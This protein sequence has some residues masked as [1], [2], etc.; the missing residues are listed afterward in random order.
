MCACGETV[1]WNEQCLILLQSKYDWSNTLDPRLRNSCHVMDKY[2][3]SHDYF[4]YSVKHNIWLFRDTDPE[5]SSFIIK[6]AGKLAWK[7]VHSCTSCLQGGGIIYC[8]TV[9]TVSSRQYI[10]G[11]L[12]EWVDFNNCTWGATKLEIKQILPGSHPKNS[13]AVLLS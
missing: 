9:S 4:F 8:F 13:S 10:Y 12:P 7:D 2:K 6:T 1:L 11:Y 3:C 5:Y